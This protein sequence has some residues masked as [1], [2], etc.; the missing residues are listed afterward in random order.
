MGLEFWLP[1]TLIMLVL[2][3][4]ALYMVTKYRGGSGVRGEGRVVMDKRVEED[5]RFKS[6]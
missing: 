1:P 4:W 3:V 5:T 2:A 6:D